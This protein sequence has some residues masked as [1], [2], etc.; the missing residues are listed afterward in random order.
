MHMYNVCLYILIHTME[1]YSAVKKNETRPRA[2]AW[3]E[4]EMILLSEV[5]QAERGEPHVASLTLG[6]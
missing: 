2:A 6:I 4:L 1:Y 5:S 3:M